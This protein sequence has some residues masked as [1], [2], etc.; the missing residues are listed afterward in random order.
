MKLKRPTISYATRFVVLATAFATGCSAQQPSLKE[1]FKK[2]FLIGGALNDDV[3]NGKDP[4]AAAIAERHF[5]AITAENV[6]KWM[7]IHPEPNRFDFSAADRFVDFG[8]KNNMFIIGHTLVWHW[9]TPRWVFEDVNGNNIDRET[10]LARMKEHISTVVGRYKGKVNGWDVVNEA[11]DDNGELRKTKWLEIIGED[12][13]ARAFEYAHEADPDAELY[14]NDFSLENPAKRDG[15]VRLVKDLQSKGVPIHG[16]GIQAQAWRLPPDYP[17]IQDV[18]DFINAVSALGV[19]V[20][21]TELCVDVLPSAM[22]QTGADLRHR[23]ELSEELNPYVD[24]LPDDVQKKLADRYAE[25]FSLFRKHSDKISRV[26]LWGVYDKTSWLN[27]WPVRGRTNYPL[28]FDRDYKPKPA[29][30]AV[31]KTASEKQKGSSMSDLEQPRTFRNPVIPGFFPDPSICRVGD[32]YY[33]VHSTFEYFPGVPVMHSK[34]LVHWRMLGYCLTRK[35]QL[36]LDKMKSSG[37]IYAPTIRY[38]DGTFYMI[39]TNVTAGGNFY[40]T[41]KNP[42]GP[43]SEPVW[44]KDGGGIDPSLFFDDDGKVYYHRQEGG[45]HGCTAQTTINLETGKLEGELK[46]IWRGTGGIW[47]EGP[48]LYK[49]NGKYYLMISEGGTSYG[50]MVTVARSDSPFGP[51]ESN[52]NNPILTHRELDGN[53]IRAVGHADL[54]ETP[55]GW[56]LVCLAIRPKGGYHHHIGRETFLAPVVFN[57]A[58]WPVVNKTGTIDLVMTAP[59]LP[60]HIWPKE[61]TRDNFDSKTLALKWNYVRNPNERDYSLTERP[62]F[63]R[64]RGS[65]V[66]MC[67]QDSPTFVGQRQTDFNCVAS[68]LLEFD[69][70]SGNEEA[71]LVARQDDRNHY[72]IA[73]TLKDGKRKVL[74]RKVVKGKIIEPVQ[75]VDIQPGPVLLSV[76]A[77]PLS[78]EFSCQSADSSREV[79]G[80]GLTK[81]LSVESIGFDYG[82]CFTGVYFGMYSSGNGKECTRPADFDWFEYSPDAH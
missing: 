54:V 2:D 58:G 8:L 23:A 65:D 60:Q 29:F 67:D 50:H 62:G 53:P 77:T 72:E 59:K 49:I 73:I 22:R 5:S 4:G 1:A 70:L 37:G 16:V 34:D 27:N 7:P 11:L 38:H 78:Y 32:D 61:P 33:T 44:I 80:T 12:F 82:M 20:M 63:L 43:W 69:P 31:I 64:L 71:G 56:W 35:S 79:L 45:R 81:D 46:E 66:T 48:H 52:P 24:G 74:F 30:Y 42:A 68:T 25:L 41:A 13:I 51:F 17:V 47:P 28:L 3:V 21:V 18:E 15:C 36:P 26:T 39:T 57:E 10:L 76:K 9:Q 14:Y 55:D 19:K 40:V 6:M 75:Y